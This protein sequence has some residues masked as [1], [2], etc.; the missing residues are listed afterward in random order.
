RSRAWERA[1]VGA[2]AELPGARRGVRVSL[3][4]P[5]P[6]VLY[7][8]RV[9]HAGQRGVEE[10]IVAAERGNARCVHHLPHDL[11]ERGIPGEIWQAEIPGGVVSECVRRADGHSTASWV[12]GC[13]GYLKAI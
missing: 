8:E 4:P 9:L 13:H 2:A 12:G 7:R 11:G 10:P 3:H 5:R 1:R 6:L